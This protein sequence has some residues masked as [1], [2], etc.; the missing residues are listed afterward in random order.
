MLAALRQDTRFGSCAIEIKVAHGNA[1]PVSRLEIHQREALMQCALSFTYKIP[2]V[3]YDKK[4]FDAVLFKDCVA[5]VVIVF[6]SP[7]VEVFAVPV[8]SFPQHGSVTREYA[9]LAGLVVDV[10]TRGRIR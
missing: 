7:S 10:S 5:Y 2:D 8:V 4:P 1:L 6:P 3:G 9:R